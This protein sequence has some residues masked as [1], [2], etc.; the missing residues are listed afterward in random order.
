MSAAFARVA[1]VHARLRDST[2][3]TQSLSIAK[4]AKSLVSLL[5]LTNVQHSYG[6]HPVLA[7]ASIVR[8]GCEGAAFPAAHGTAVAS[9]LVGESEGFESVIP[10]ATLYASDIF[11]GHGGGSLSLLAIALDWMAREKVAVVNISLV[12]AKSPLLTGLVRCGH[13]GKKMH[14][15]YSGRT[16]RTSAA[17]YYLCTSAPP[18]RA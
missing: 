11:C 12:G 16:T 18:P 1:A 17:L 13:C 15:R 7:G 14:V 8:H 4:S 9:L 5:S 2:S 3:F 10:G 6:S